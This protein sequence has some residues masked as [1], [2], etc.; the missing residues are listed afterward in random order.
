MSP[1]VA[2]VTA[3]YGQYDTLKPVLPQSRP[4]TEWVLVTDREP[5]PVAAEGWRVVVEPR[6]GVS[7]RRAAKQP[8]LRPWEYTG[9]SAS[10]W[11][12][13]SLRV[14]S[15]WFVA[16]AL[17]HSAPLAQFPHPERDCLYAEADADRASG[18]DDP[19]ALGYQAA[20]YR[21]AGHPRNWGLWASGVIVR[22]HTR[23]VKRF[24][25]AWSDSVE[26]WSHRDQVSEPYALR[27]AGLWPESLPGTYTDN[28][29]LSYEPDTPL[30][31]CGLCRVESQRALHPHPEC[32]L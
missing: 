32:P 18:L 3:L 30:L 27:L 29:W 12:D 4:F 22:Q 2:V 8:K 1:Q 11:L 10:I 28:E 25:K 20:A 7:P 9:A 5:D 23:D 15:P 19:D 13:A 14:T 24:C 16:Q 21:R 26:V 17:E 6:S 31:S